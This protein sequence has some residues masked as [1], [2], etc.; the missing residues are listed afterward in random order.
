MEE[1]PDVIDWSGVFDRMLGSEDGPLSH[2]MLAR[3]L[4][5]TGGLDPDRAW[6]KVY[7]AH[8][9]EELLQVTVG[10][11][12]GVRRRH[13]FV[14]RPDWDEVNVVVFPIWDYVAEEDAL[15]SPTVSRSEIMEYVFERN[16]G[17]V[18]YPVIETIVD[19]VDNFTPLHSAPRPESRLGIRRDIRGLYSDLLDEH[20]A[21]GLSRDN[22][23]SDLA[24]RGD[25]V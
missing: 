8:D 20:G 10:L 21:T 22:V 25:S 6:E 18:P 9:E 4:R 5:N 11:Y 3:H 7:E 1:Y 13:Y 24:T 15:Q 17:Q 12:P 16:E 23:N 2:L 14:P 19:H